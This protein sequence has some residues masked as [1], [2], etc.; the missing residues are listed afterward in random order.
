MA[1][2]FVDPQTPRNPDAEPQFAMGGWIATAPFEDLLGMHIE[3]AGDGRARLSMPFLVQYAQGGGVMH[4]GALTSLADTAVAMAIK[5][6]LPDGAIFATTELKMEFLAP[7]RFGPVT[8]EAQV[9]GP[10]GREFY[11]EALLRDQQGGLLARFSSVF[12]LARGQ[13]P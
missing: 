12:R 10:E 3:Q 7:A 11:G 2:L 1:T 13:Q 4:G 9:R 6:L 5:S 8:A